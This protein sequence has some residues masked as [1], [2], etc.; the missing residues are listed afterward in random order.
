MKKIFMMMALVAMTLLTACGGKKT[1]G[2]D[3]AVADST[4]VKDTTAVA[5]S[6]QTVAD[7]DTIDELVETLQKVMK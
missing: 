1:N 6:V 5:D 2:D 4:S 7:E 3:A